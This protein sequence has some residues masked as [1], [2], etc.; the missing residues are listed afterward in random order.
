SA[1]TA[2]GLRAEDE[3]KP[4]PA[5]APA[6]DPDA[7]GAAPVP[8]RAGKD[9]EYGRRGGR[10]REKVRGKDRE[11]DKEGKGGEG[12][13]PASEDEITD[14]KYL[15]DLASVHQ[16]YGG[17]KL[18][19]KLLERAAVLAKDSKDPQDLIRIFTSQASQMQRDKNHKE[20]ARLYEE[21]LKLVNEPGQRAGHMLALARCYEG[22]ED[23]DA[24]ESTLKQLLKEC[25]TNTGKRELSWV[26]QTVNRQLASIWR[27]KPERAA[28]AE[29]EAVG[30]L[31]KDPNDANALETLSQI[32]TQ[33]KPDH[34]K[35]VAVLEKLW[36]LK[37]EDTQVTGILAST[38]IQMQKYDKA[39]EVYKAMMEKVPASKKTYAYQAASALIQAERQ[40]DAIAF[41]KE[42]LLGEDSD[43]SSL[44]LM[45]SLLDR[46]GKAEEAEK[47]YADAHEATTQLKAKLDEIG[48]VL[49]RHLENLKKIKE[50]KQ[51]ADRMAQANAWVME[52]GGRTLRRGVNMQ[53][54]FDPAF[55][56][57]FQDHQMVM[58]ERVG[59]QIQKVRQKSQRLA[60][61]ASEIDSNLGRIDRILGR[62]AGKCG[63]SV[64]QSMKEASTRAEN[65]SELRRIQGRAETHRASSGVSS[66]A[67]AGSTQPATRSRPS[68]MDGAVEDAIGALDAPLENGG[69][70]RQRMA[71]AGSRDT[72]SVN[73]SCRDSSFGCYNE[74]HYGNEIQR[75][76]A[77]R[78]A[79]QSELQSKGADGVAG[80]ARR[81]AELSNRERSELGKF[82]RETDE[83]AFQARRAEAD[84]R[85]RREC[86][87]NPLACRTL[88]N[89]G[90][91]PYITDEDVRRGTRLE[92]QNLTGNDEMPVMQT[93]GSYAD[94]IQNLDASKI[95]ASAVEKTL[96]QDVKKTES[97]VSDRKSKLAD[98]EKGRE[99]IRQAEAMLSQPDSLDP[100]T[101]TVAGG[102]TDRNV[103]MGDTVEAVNANPYVAGAV[104]E[105]MNQEG[106]KTDGMSRRELVD[107]METL[108]NHAENV[109]LAAG[110]TV[111]VA[112]GGG[113]V[114]AAR[115]GIG[116]A[117]G[118]LAKD[119]LISG[120]PASVA[121]IGNLYHMNQA[122]DAA[123]ATGSIISGGAAA[124][125][126][127][128]VNDT[129]RVA[130]V[131][132]GVL[133]PTRTSRLLGASGAAAKSALRIGDD[134]PFSRAAGMA[135]NVAADA[136]LREPTAVP[137]RAIAS[138]LDAVTGQAVAR[139]DASAPPLVASSPGPLGRDA[140][141]LQGAA[142]PLEGAESLKVGKL[143]NGSG[144]RGVVY[145]LSE[146]VQGKTG[147]LKHA[148]GMSNLS[149]EFGAYEAQLARAEVRRP[150]ILAVDPKG[151]WMITEKVD[152]ISGRQARR[153]ISGE[154][155]SSAFQRD[156]VEKGLVPSGTTYEGYRRAMVE[157]LGRTFARVERNKVPLDLKPEN[158]VVNGQGEFVLVDR[159]LSSQGWTG[160]VTQ[161]D[162]WVRNLMTTG[163]TLDD[164]L[165]KVF[166]SSVR[167]EREAIASGASRR[168]GTELENLRA[169]PRPERISRASAESE[170]I[171]RRALSEGRD[172]AEV[173]AD[174]AGELL[175]RKLTPR[176]RAAVRESH[177]IGGGRAIGAYTAREISAKDRVLARAGFEKSERELLVRKGVTGDAAPT[178]GRVDRVFTQKIDDYVAESRALHARDGRFRFD[179]VE[180]LKAEHQ[181]G[182][183]NDGIFYARRGTDSY[184]VK[185]LS[186]HPAT[187]LEEIRN[188]RA[189]QELGVGPESHLVP[190]TNGRYALVMR[191][192]PGVNLKDVLMPGKT[193]EGTR[194]A[195]ERTL[196]VKTASK[197]EA[198]RIFKAEVAANPGVAG[199]MRRLGK[200]LGENRFHTDDLQLMVDPRKGTVRVIDPAAFQRK[201][202][203]TVKPSED[204]D[205]MIAALNRSPSGSAS[206]SPASAHAVTPRAAGI[207]E[208]KEL[209]P[210]QRIAQA[211]DESTA[212]ERR[213]LAQGRN[214]MVV[215]QERAQEILDRRLSQMEKDAIQH[216][217]LVG[218]R[219]KIGEYTAREIARKDRVLREAGFP[220]HEREVLLRRGIT[221]HGD[222]LDFT[223][224]KTAVRPED[225]D[226][227]FTRIPASRGVADGV[228]LSR[229]FSRIRQEFYDDAAKSFEVVSGKDLMKP[230]DL[231][232]GGVS[233]LYRYEK[234]DGVRR[235]LQNGGYV[236]KV[237]TEST[238]E[239]ARAVGRTLQKGGAAEMVRLHVESDITSNL[240]EWTTR[241]NGLP[242]SVTSAGEIRFRTTPDPEAKYLGTSKISRSKLGVDEGGIV[243]MDPTLI[244]SD[245]FQV[246]VPGGTAG[247][248]RWV[249]VG[250]SEGLDY[251]NR[252]LESSPR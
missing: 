138:E 52:R 30:K 75:A 105:K 35:A 150:E 230:V 11:D 115:M 129:G 211:R 134:I 40:D 144:S 143:F 220:R 28:S 245:R 42:H 12:D 180:A 86:Q 4:A 162:T 96:A 10:D 239:G 110:L 78:A 111:G 166:Q 120:V 237:F 127:V 173:R 62:S 6:P 226:L 117:A 98:I 210:E 196:G 84:A 108:Q 32:Y 198:V 37:P 199:E 128:D 58:Q 51:E 121:D 202:S 229:D 141:D 156:F 116:K 182:K 189:M 240:V 137:S 217:H 204:V 114:A 91:A 23:F 95:D 247:S 249:R 60:A 70:F 73:L 92:Q 100:E 231:D 205:A 187:V 136:A 33:I 47:I 55:A 171:E 79:L 203:A 151:N 188:A 31:E 54:C 112:T 22:M 233:Y 94:Q 46:A 9:R 185:N 74:N 67:Q 251:L 192:E 155:D 68:G 153:I 101:A 83:A 191:E 123:V 206:R 190:R 132:A 93:T 130:L 142:V 107:R 215:R 97:Y 172:A 163:K 59:P 39:V 244:S 179:S 16:R 44:S 212:I 27:A 194:M 133:D 213:A 90:Q 228:R 164:G 89:S 225:L 236:P 2:S 195:I 34:A 15:L 252:I 243:T 29:A 224:A 218:G 21:V 76:E 181:S 61:R 214:P 19:A 13:G 119:A 193:T 63:E 152:G 160:V 85:I 131:A 232:G 88:Q 161:T 113:A 184:V 146:P 221:G 147:L 99:K 69:S 139:G 140:R 3:P 87:A 66:G 241:S 57:L 82:N 80:E 24:A 43:E 183:M 177:E 174:R 242:A 5:P 126:L 165:S 48:R 186:E 102:M 207:R 53:G 135:D 148:S 1:C 175:G 109:Q 157:D 149:D 106:V 248:G 36:A 38:L 223:G 200:V 209:T 71:D 65:D 26:P 238:E 227:D 118:S 7:E 56:S 124:Q 18:A 81:I 45:A 216:A 168:G 246:F 8:P 178:A 176:E 170:A 49:N 167:A 250:S 235:V 145:E 20:A 103:F 25:E 158:F 122:Q 41:A 159:G 125:E 14:P 64:A 197:E 17:N 154:V 104:A 234:P 219:K 77:N 222:D 50:L 208:L 169:A 72:G 201:A